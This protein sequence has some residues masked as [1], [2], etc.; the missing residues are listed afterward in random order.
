[1]DSDLK[2]GWISS[3]DAREGNAIVELVNAAVGDEGVLGYASA[4][5]AAEARYFIF[6]LSLRMA[7]GEAHVFLAWVN[8]VPAVLA[9]LTVTGMHNCRHR[10][11]IS[12]G[13]VAP[14]FRGR[15]MVE[16]SFR[17]IVRRS[18]S[19]GVEQLVLDV[20]EGTRA[21]RLWERFGFESYGVLEDYARFGGVSHRGHFMVQTTASLRARVF[22]SI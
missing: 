9:I 18:E 15:H 19:L 21:H 7:S 16:M 1:M 3:L 14:Q 17:E 2:C 5:T 10:A 4:M 12:K 6:N 22:P 20:R 11:E 13:V 8:E